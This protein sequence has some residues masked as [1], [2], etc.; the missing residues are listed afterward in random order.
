MTLRRHLIKEQLPGLL[1]TVHRSTGLTNLTAFCD[2]QYT[3]AALAGL[4]RTTQLS[5]VVVQFAH[6]RTLH[7]LSALKL[8]KSYVLS[9][10]APDRLD[11]SAVQKLPTLESLWLQDGTF[12]CF[13]AFLPLKQLVLKHAH[14][15]AAFEG[16]FALILEPLVVCNCHF[17]KLHANGLS[18]CSN[19][20]TF[21]CWDAIMVGSDKLHTFRLV[22]VDGLYL[23]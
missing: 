5:C 13:P 23:A 10:P 3:A 16:A 11:V 2:T 1:D 8:M 17:R 20:R 15:T 14:I 6:T 19:L 4:A 7:T 9:R 12:D 21:V 22:R 18:A